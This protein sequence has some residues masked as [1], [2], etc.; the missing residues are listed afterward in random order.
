METTL[1]SKEEA[2]C[3]V[4][5]AGRFLSAREKGYWLLFNDLMDI[6]VIVFIVL[7]HP[8]C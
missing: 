1:V 8:K 4:K 6:V 2:V 5:F 3:G 7:F